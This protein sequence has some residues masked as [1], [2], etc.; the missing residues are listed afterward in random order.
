MHRLIRILVFAKDADS[1]LAA[2]NKIVGDK[3]IWPHGMF[4]YASD[5]AFGPEDFGTR[6]M[7]TE[8][9]GKI[10]PVL[11]V[12]TT[13]FPCE[14][15]SGLLQAE[16]ALQFTREFFDE[17]MKSLR[18]HVTNYTDDE[19]FNEVEGIGEIEIDGWEIY[20]DPSEFQYTCSLLGGKSCDGIFL[21]EFH[22]WPVTRVR[23]LQQL[24][25]ITDTNHEGL[26]DIP[27]LPLWI[28]PFDV[29][30]FLVMDDMRSVLEAT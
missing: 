21:Y 19:L 16:D 20:D 28:V 22:G 14:D 25:T 10:P 18:H 9:W 12:S 2:A 4:D 7:L 24:I 26:D 8:R 15:S 17:N 23:H 1:A 13:R 29:H 11:Q 27:D 5:F 6:E 30:F 3:L